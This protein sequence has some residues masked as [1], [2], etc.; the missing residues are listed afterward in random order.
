MAI[1]LFPIS[2]QR[3]R[4][5]L[6]ELDD[7]AFGKSY[8]APGGVDRLLNQ[9]VDKLCDLLM[10]VRRRSVEHPRSPSCSVE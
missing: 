6:A 5:P 9:P 1:E 10:Q 3:Y 7:M 8:D 4:A 2:R